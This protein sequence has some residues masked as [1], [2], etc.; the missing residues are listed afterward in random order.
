MHV[1]NISTTLTSFPV[2]VVL[3]TD[4]F[5]YTTSKNYKEEKTKANQTHALFAYLHYIRSRS[6]RMPFTSSMATGLFTST[7]LLPC[8]FCSRLFCLMEPCWLYEAYPTWWTAGR[9]ETTAVLW[10]TRIITNN[11]QQPSHIRN[12]STAFWRF[13][14]TFFFL[15]LGQTPG[16]FRWRHY[17]WRSVIHL[18]QT[19][20]LLYMYF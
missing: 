9:T 7:T 6:V 12:V 11:L 16:A 10:P 8:C 5:M 14:S 2:W 17:A 15:F 20:L 18:H 3:Q 13:T 1:S 4:H 19:T